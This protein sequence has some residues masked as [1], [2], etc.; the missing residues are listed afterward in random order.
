MHRI[1]CFSRSTVRAGRTVAKQKVAAP[2]GKSKES[3]SQFKGRKVLVYFYPKAD[4]PGCT[5]QACG[6]R[7]AWGEFERTGAVV[8]AIMRGD[9]GLLGPSATERLQAGDLLTKRQAWIVLAALQ[10]LAVRHRHAT[11]AELGALAVAAADPDTQDGRLLLA[12]ASTF[13]A[14]FAAWCRLALSLQVTP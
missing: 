10:R 11:A 3:L 12:T 14:T 4:T 7:D 6:I 13:P 2:K 8:L 9:Q 1:A 5:T